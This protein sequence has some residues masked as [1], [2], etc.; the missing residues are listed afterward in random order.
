MRTDTPKTI[1]LKDYTPFPY[2]VDKVDLTFRIAPGKTLVAAKIAFTK[3]DGGT[4]D[5]ILNGERLKLISVK[6]NGTDAKYTVDEK[7]LTLPCPGEKFTLETEVEICPEENTALEGLYMSGGN[8]CTQ[9]EAEG[10]RKIT[11]F[12]DRPDVMT[13]FTTRIEADKKLFPVLLSNGNL[14][15]EDSL[16]LQGEGRGEGEGEGLHYTIW[17]DPF[18]K[19]CYLFA[20]VAGNLVDIRDSFTTMTGRVVDLRIYVRDGDQ[21]QCGWAMESLKKSMDWDER[22]YGREYELNRFNIVAV[23]DFNM[24]AMENT[25]L[26]IFNTALV[27]AQPDTATDRDFERVEGVIA[28]EYF[29]NWTGNRVT[30]RD[31]FQLSL[32]EGL[33]VFRDQ[34]FTADM[35]SR[36]VKR[37]DDVILLRRM[38][39]P[40][41]AGPMAHPIRPDQFIE[42]SNFYTVT[43]YEKGAEVIR[44][45]HTLLG[46]ETYRKATDLYFERFDGMAVTCDDFIKC[47]ED[48]SGIDL[49]QFKL[50]Y[51]QAGTPE[52][53]ATSHYDADAQ[54]FTLTLKQHTP[55]TPGQPDKKPMHIP[56]ALGLVGPNGGDM[57]DTIIHL[58]EQSQDFVFE[59]IPSRPIPSILRG[60]S[61]PV[62]LTTDLT[63]DDYRFLM[64][65]DRDGFNRW[66]AG[67]ILS[68]R[69]LGRMIDALE[70]GQPAQTDVTFIKTFGAMLEQGFDAKADM[71]LL[72]RALA[73]PDLSIIAQDRKI[74]NPD[75]IYKARRQV[76]SEI[77][78]AHRVAL[79]SLYNHHCAP[80]TYSVDP[81]SVGKRSIKNLAL[82][83]LMTDQSQQAIA[84]AKQQYD[85]A[86]NMTDRTAALA[87]LVETSSPERDDALADF[88]TRFKDYPLVIDKWFTMQAVAIRP[89]TLDDVAALA[90]HPAFTILNPNRVRSLYSAFAM[91]NPVMFHDVSGRGYDFLG[92]AILTLNTKNPQIAS[93]LLTPLREWRRYT[94]DRQ[95]KMKAILERIAATPELSPDV[96]EVVSK[97]LK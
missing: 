68:L 9:C 28:H 85:S 20:L 70:S 84:L 95:D 11:Y 79:Q 3:K 54:R 14:I 44:M 75:T 21:A 59:N 50:W 42:I 69:M 61:A 12:P 56:V 7:F 57:A 19:P 92:D 13:I 94:T 39:F 16:S 80:V 72:A 82:S 8:Y 4:P 78:A 41:D 26:N 23:S 90:K 47:M 63:D 55:A 29:H 27:L 83:Y 2:T 15:K 51:S 1:Y 53:H 46:P 17:H 97:S 96:F 35:N 58:K 52:I 88:F 74:V 89:T 65:H 77:L 37:I 25:S 62:K 32:K 81:V 91:N 34:E 24:G 30:C 6:L 93:R 10:F 76:M 71:A 49:S 38:Q 31:W 87:Q 40:E 64:I 48:A 36:G 33:T 86:N 60:F 18:P 67:Q 45:Q 5:L 73:L 66:E 22:V 43:V